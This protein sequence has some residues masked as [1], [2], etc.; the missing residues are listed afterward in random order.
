MNRHL[1]EE[2]PYDLHH[3]GM[4][5]CCKDGLKGLDDAWMAV[6]I[7][8]KQTPA[9][10]SF[11]HEFL[12]S[13]FSYD[14][15]SSQESI[16]AV[17]YLASPVSSPMGFDDPMSPRSWVN[18]SLSPST[19]F[20]GTPF[21]CE[22]GSGL[23]VDGISDSTTDDESRRYC[24]RLALHVRSSGRAELSLGDELRTKLQLGRDCLLESHILVDTSGVVL[25]RG[26]SSVPDAVTAAQLALSWTPQS[27]IRKVAG[28][29]SN[30]RKVQDTP[31]QDHDPNALSHD[32]AH[33]RQS[34]GPLD[35]LPLDGGVRVQPRVSP[36]SQ[37]R[38]ARKSTGHVGSKRVSNGVTKPK[39]TSRRSKIEGEFTLGV[40]RI[41]YQG[42]PTR[43]FRCRFCLATFTREEHRKR[44]EHTH[45][46]KEKQVLHRCTLCAHTAN[47]NDNMQQHEKRHEN[48]GG[49]LYIPKIQR[50]RESSRRCK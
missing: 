5:E 49:R 28:H 19:Y 43:S 15:D 16:Q 2:V 50:T 12:P 23:H 29:S 4:V 25:P 24:E 31:G 17:S 20:D 14:L 32:V 42:T 13:S 36:S 41:P 18:D 8:C 38:R 44:H 37:G 35:A 11:S 34:G 10:K 40:T 22:T 27:T 9:H 26:D 47:R 39:S 45:L 30:A 1:T 7:G 6:S 46:P 48:E 3:A 33:S 21:E